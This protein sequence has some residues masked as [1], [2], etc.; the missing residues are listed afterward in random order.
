VW[1]AYLCQ[2]RRARYF[3]KS[4]KKSSKLNPPQ[5]SELKEIW[6][7]IVEKRGM[8]HILSDKWATHRSVDDKRGED[9]S[10]HMELLLSL[11]GGATSWSGDHLILSLSNFNFNL[12]DFHPKVLKFL[13]WLFTE[14]EKLYDQPAEIIDQK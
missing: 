4:L 3:I 1:K 11:E 9:E 2:L 8:I 13:H 6:D 7:L 14:T 10:L 5:D 12:C